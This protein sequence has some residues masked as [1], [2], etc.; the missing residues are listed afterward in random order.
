MTTFATANPLDYARADFNTFTVPHPVRAAAVDSIIKE[1]RAKTPL[2][3]INERKAPRLTVSEL[4]DMDMDEIKQRFYNTGIDTRGPVTKFLDIIDLPRNVLF[5]IAASDTAKRKANMGDTAAFGLGRV[6]TSDVLES[7]GVRPGL[8]TGILGFV[9]DVALDPLTYLGPGGWGAKAASAGGRTV[10]YT[11][12]G[13]KALQEAVQATKAGRVASS[14]AIAK[15]LETLG[16]TAES[17]AAHPDKAK[18]A[19][20]V[21]RTLLG[22]K[23]TRFNKVMSVFGEDAE[24]AAVENTRTLAD[25][26]TDYTHATKDEATNARI[27]AAKDVHREVGRSFS[28]GV[29]FYKDSTK[30]LGIGMT[31][32]RDMAH[33][34]G[35]L[36]VPFTD[37]M[38]SVP[39]F[40]P[41]ANQQNLVAS[42]V[43]N[44]ASNFDEK[45]YVEGIKP[46]VE[47]LDE[48][49]HNYSQARDAYDQVIGST[50]AGVEDLVQTP[51]QAHREF[52][53]YAYGL[54]QPDGTRTGGAVTQMAK[55]L[56]EMQA[57][58]MTSFADMLHAQ[59]VFKA[60]A[61]KAQIAREEWL[62][63]KDVV[64]ETGEFAAAVDSDVD[65]LVNTDIEGL[66]GA[67]RAENMHR[68]SVKSKIPTTIDEIDNEYAQHV[69]ARRD[70]NPA[71]KSDVD[72]AF[73]GYN[74]RTTG[75][76]KAQL[77]KNSDP[78]F[79]DTATQEWK[80][81]RYTPPGEERNNLSRLAVGDS[82]TVDITES[83]YPD[84]VVPD[85][86]ERVYD[87]VAR[88]DSDIL[89][90]FVSKENQAFTGLQVGLKE[91]GRFSGNVAKIDLA[92]VKPNDVW[93]M[94]DTQVKV[95]GI[96]PDSGT[97]D[98][99]VLMP[100]ENVDVTTTVVRPSEKTRGKKTKTTRQ[101]TPTSV[102]SQERPRYYTVSMDQTPYA[103]KA[104][105]KSEKVTV[106]RLDDMGEL[107]L[108]EPEPT[109]S[110]EAARNMAFERLG[111]T[112]DD[113]AEAR[114]GHG[115]EYAGLDEK[116]IRE[117]L[118]AKR[119]DEQRAKMNAR[120]DGAVPLYLDKA[121]RVDRSAYADYLHA[122]AEAAQRVVD[123]SLAPYFSTVGSDVKAAV[124]AVREAFNLGAD[125][126]GSGIMQSLVSAT[127]KYS[128]TNK[129]GQK[130]IH[131]AQGLERF[132]VNHMGL[133]PSIANDMVKQAVKAAN[134]ADTTA[135]KTA[136]ADITRTLTESGITPAELTHANDL[137]MAFLF[138]G[139]TPIEELIARDD[140]AGEM[141][142]KAM[143][144]GILQDP[145]KA[146]A[147]RGLAEKYRGIFNQLDDG[148]GIANYAP[149][150]LTP[151]AKNIID[152][153]R[154]NRMN[155]IGARARGENIPKTPVEEMT[156]TFEKKRS[157]IEHAWTDENNNPVKVLESELA[158][159]AY[160]PQDL[161][162]Y[163]K[164]NPA[165]HDYLVERIKHAQRYTELSQADKLTKVKSYYL[166][167]ME[168][169]RR[170]RENGMF[171]TLTNNALN[172]NDF[173][174]SNFTAA[175]AARLGSQERK[176]AN[177]LLQQYV[178]PHALRL[179]EIEL[180]QAGEATGKAVDMKTV[181][182]TPVTLVNEGGKKTIYLGNKKY[183]QPT[184]DVSNEFSPL[185]DLFTTPSGKPIANEFY[186]EEIADIINDTAGF[187][188][189]RASGGM[190]KAFGEA[191]AASRMTS[192]LKGA[193]TLS[194]YWKVFTLLHPS[195][196]I[197]DILGNLFFM[198][199]MG[200]NP[201]SAIK[202][203]KDAFKMM[204]ANAAGDRDV[205]RE[206]MVKGRSAADHFDGEFGQ[207]V[208][209]HQAAES[210]MHLRQSGETIEPFN[211]SVGSV[212]NKTVRG[213]FA[214]AK[215]EARQMVD[216]SWQAAGKTIDNQNVD[217][218]FATQEGKAIKQPLNAL[219]QQG[220]IR[221]VW[222]PWAHLNG[223]ANDWLKT[224][225]YLSLLD[226]GYDAA[227]AARM[228]SEK[229]LDMSVLTSTDRS[230]RRFVPFYNWMKNSGV[231]GI[232]EMLR[233][234]KF[235]SI[236]PKV[237]QAL[238]ESFNG[239]QNLPENAR[240]SWIR[241]QLALQIGTDPDTRR[242]LT[243]TSSLPTEAA[244]YAL[245]FLFSP[246]MGS[247]ALQDSLAYGIN[248]ITPAIK[249]P[250]ELG[251]RREFFTK[252][253]IDGQGGDITPTEYLMQQIRPFREFGVGSIR[254]GPLQR[255]F[256]DSPVMGISRA[257][258]GGR[259]QPFDEERRVSNLQREYDDR[260]DAL[261]RRIG[262]S[263]R[264]GQKEESLRRRV[265]LLQLFNQMQKLSLTI[266][267]WATGQI[268]GLS[269][270]PTA[271]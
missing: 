123:A 180:A 172:G 13:A 262:I 247:G 182:G 256:A 27:A 177:Q 189:D 68:E 43:K 104:A 268:A 263:E 102:E 173:M 191:D 42:L 6:N 221:R 188:S 205:L 153:Q 45:K 96:N 125:D 40:T 239:E 89:N 202:N 113:I 65:K 127:T 192:I 134:V 99:E 235:F 130:M 148:T 160:T 203:A 251:S 151:Q 259:L 46:F 190:A 206:M 252:R 179:N 264:E 72:E 87:S 16:H 101:R 225:A 257:L 253:T 144:S 241:D 226:Q 133:P 143:Q 107:D 24:R 220:L 32:S 69:Q 219:F 196:T 141:I 70:A 38:V 50:A 53:D 193:D 79:Y 57:D 25:D 152:Y 132:I 126:L 36:H 115:T 233:N 109:L 18:L 122:K 154:R 242:A 163:N 147:I 49:W 3:A 170:V 120:E 185:K 86:V 186:P 73:G 63:A 44:G 236:A 224:T 240:P 82:Q 271:N 232:R 100:P 9:G 207:V 215:A 11:R 261:R 55:T 83:M 234:P 5:N 15:Y 97:V 249:I 92:K 33:G 20:E 131:E 255:A 229:M 4:N 213:D 121:E 84:G 12:A 56:E 114:L 198:A 254:G 155:I 150:V 52:L 167:P 124:D 184:I 77:S 14:P 10:S 112:P 59:D 164:K 71:I 22:G 2:S 95:V 17:I 223:M 238:E 108:F 175:V 178:A 200:I 34:S 64:T 106:E 204:R 116:A 212:L 244:T 183:K 158:Y 118:V 21:E 265:E 230:V 166:S 39:S 162:E 231:L 243:L 197:N 270:E 1:T 208:G 159:L 26:I 157:T 30:P 145:K 267:K 19:S 62:R 76:S 90:D 85:D 37:S 54:Q 60:Y 169:N 209:S 93:F 58:P 165:Y 211:T 75:I 140:I 7:L 258:V 129:Y 269:S 110:R 61:G 105:K 51:E 88:P 245:S 80:D 194:G 218:P 103:S 187:F 156:H 161:A 47:G 31:T 149:N 66:R 214:G 199:N 23:Q 67:Q 119:L 222:Q 28:K 176:Y 48:R 98:L 128:P 248:S 91:S 8:A 216:E 181:Q 260:V 201:Q 217:R 237:K 168:I 246:F 78:A 250:L 228:V 117:R 74:K 266:P 142:Q 139:D 29:R 171:N 135:F 210:T 111:I 174:H 81:L 138:A 137:A 35:I 146:E 227:S 41:F 94:G 195:W 136:A